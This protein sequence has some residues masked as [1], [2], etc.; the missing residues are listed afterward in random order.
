[1]K[2]SVVSRWVDDYEECFAERFLLNWEKCCDEI[3]IVNGGKGSDRSKEIMIGHP[4]VRWVDFNVSVPGINGGERNPEGQH[5]NVCLDEC[6]DADWIV[7][8][9]ADAW[10]NIPL[11]TIFKDL[12]Y[13]IDN[14]GYDALFTWLYYLGPK[15]KDRYHYPELLAGT[16]MTAW[17]NSLHIRAD[18]TSRFEPALDVSS[19]KNIYHLDGESWKEAFFYRL[20]MTYDTE[21]LIQRKNQFYKNV[22]GL[23]FPH[24][25]IRFDKKEIIP[26]SCIW[27]GE[28][29]LVTENLIMEYS[30]IVKRA[31][32][33]SEWRNYSYSRQLRRDT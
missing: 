23:D 29:E 14:E 21:E 22:H 5:I 4:L 11:Q 9:E 10:P 7:L 26:D 16:G 28:T 17:K 8:T 18:D 19:C 1:M 31:L 27:Y 33:I 15:R 24:P 3:I 12:I 2:I 6:K 30:R 32:A 13:Y 25:D 20:H